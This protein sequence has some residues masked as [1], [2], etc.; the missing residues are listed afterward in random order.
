MPEAR[1]KPGGIG[2]DP[3]RTILFDSGMMIFCSRGKKGEL[4]SLDMETS[5][6]EPEPNSELKFF[7][8][9]N[10]QKMMLVVLPR[11]LWGASDHSTMWTVL[12]MVQRAFLPLV[13]SV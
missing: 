1:K 13:A 6:Y 10:N 11:F 7:Y 4:S 5:V 12:Q 8:R 2:S 3:G 9:V